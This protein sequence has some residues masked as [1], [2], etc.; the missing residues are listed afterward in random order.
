MLK[1]MNRIALSVDIGGSKYMVGLVD[2]KGN[3]LAKKRKVWSS[4]NAKNV[5]REI[6]ESA[7]SLL[8]ENPNLEPSVIGATIPGLADPGR[9]LWVEASF[10]GIRELAVAE[11]LQERFGLPAFADND[12]QAC[13]A[14]E[15]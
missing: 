7:D 11:T 9:G 15:K 8:K 12:G 1:R 4:L 5:M 3:I 13:A 14:A 2:R 10:S 6:I